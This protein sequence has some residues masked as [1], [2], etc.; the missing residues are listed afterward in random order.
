MPVHQRS[1]AQP[2]EAYPV[3]PLARTPPNGIS[4]MTSAVLLAGATGDL[5]QRMVGELL[6]AYHWCQVWSLGC[7]TIHQAQAIVASDPPVPE[8]TRRHDSQDRKE[9]APWTMSKSSV[10]AEHGPM[11]EVRP[12]GTRTRT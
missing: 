2:D 11:P 12:S 10:K 7:L 8:R 9:R 5:G 6:L 4:S 1:T 3:G